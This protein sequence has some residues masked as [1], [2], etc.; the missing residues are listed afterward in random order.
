MQL[1]MQHTSALRSGC[2]KER[3]VV[4]HR[5]EEGELSLENSEEQ[6][7]KHLDL[8]HARGVFVIRPICQHY[9]TVCGVGREDEVQEH[10]LRV[11]SLHIYCCASHYS[12]ELDDEFTAMYKG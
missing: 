3:S 4:I 10:V 12:F 2:K 5:N 11:L 9:G 7:E 6:A 8:V 1:G